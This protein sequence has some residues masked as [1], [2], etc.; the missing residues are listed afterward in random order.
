[1]TE[2]YKFIYLPT[3]SC[4][5]ESQ[6]VTKDRSYNDSTRIKFFQGATDKTKID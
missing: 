5:A 6:S 3:L 2:L 4:H 1:M